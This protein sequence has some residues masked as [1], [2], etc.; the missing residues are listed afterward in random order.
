MGQD[1]LVSTI[2]I[3]IQSHTQEV[4]GALPLMGTRSGSIVMYHIAYHHDYSHYHHSEHVLL[5]WWYICWRGQIV[6]WCEITL[7]LF[8]SWTI[9]LRIMLH[10]LYICALWQNENIALG[11]NLVLVFVNHSNYARHV[12]R[13]YNIVFSSYFITFLIT[14]HTCTKMNVWLYC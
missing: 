9:W 10:T 8:L 14:T 6:N 5:P 3:Q 7:H 4:P 12:T 13:I 1:Q 2:L 11:C